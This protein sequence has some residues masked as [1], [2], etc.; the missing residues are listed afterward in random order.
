MRDVG[1]AGITV[2]FERFGDPADPPVL[3]LMGGGAQMINWPEGFCAEL[4]A[5][6]LHVVRFDNRDTGRSSRVENGPEPDLRAAMA[7]D[8]SS[9]SYTL[10][11]M[12]ADTVGLVDRLGLE[13]VHLVGASMGG[14]IAQTVAVEFP[15]R[16]LSLTSIMSTTGDPAVGQA[17]LRALGAVGAPPGTRAEFVRWQV[18]ALRAVSS[19]GFAFDEAGAAERAGRVFDRGF[20]LTGM[21]RQS[22]AVLASGDRTEKLRGLQLPTVV[23]HGTED[24]MCDVSGGRATAAAIPGAELVLVDGLGH[25]FPREVWPVFA[26]HVLGVVRIAQRQGTVAQRQGAQ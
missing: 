22:V 6:G 7:G 25:G 21:L 15:Q 14:M 18:A 1:P 17:D 24:R 12:A 19:P 16:V 4:V 9:A 5:R 23:I 2:A 20:D 10:S 13:R 26:D 3:L 11:D 8:F